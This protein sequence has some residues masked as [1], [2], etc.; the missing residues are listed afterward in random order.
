MQLA[1]QGSRLRLQRSVAPGW[2]V[3]PLLTVLLPAVFTTRLTVR[4]FAAA[5]TTTTTRRNTHV[6]I[7]RRTA[8]P[9]L[10]YKDYEESTTAAAGCCCFR[11]KPA[12]LRTR[13]YSAARTAVTGTTS[14]TTIPT[15]APAA[16]CGLENC[17]AVLKRNQ[18]SKAFR[19]GNQLVFSNFSKVL[20]RM[21]PVNGGVVTTG[22][23]VHGDATAPHY[24]STLCRVGRGRAGSPVRPTGRRGA[25]S[26][27]LFT[28]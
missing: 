10:V 11:G 20:H 6:R 19:N 13:H 21:P 25:R 27:S 16:L 14:I 24:T 4:A 7:P 22:D 15:P 26:D 28:S 18:Q 9:V 23:L 8:P 5:S 1:S 2:S 12:Q 3:V 17:T